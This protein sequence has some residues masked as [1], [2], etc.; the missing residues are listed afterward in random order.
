[1]K[2]KFIVS[3]LFFLNACCFGVFIV[4]TGIFVPL[5]ITAML[6]KSKSGFDNQGMDVGYYISAYNSGIKKVD[7]SYASDST[8]RY[9]P[10]IDKYTVQVKPNTPLAYYYFLFKLIL[11]TICITSSWFSLK[12][13]TEIK[14]GNPFNFRSIKYL[15]I[16]AILFIS[17]DIIISINN[18]IFNQFIHQSELHSR[19]Q[20]P[21]TLSIGNGIILGLVIWVIAIIFQRGMELQNEND[22]TV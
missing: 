17:L 6:D 21:T 1:M 22:L 8:I 3:V 14:Q 7:F 19:F 10:V 9:S 18:L 11:L 13:L 20:L 2:P 15:K 12:I 16:I 5:S 4:A